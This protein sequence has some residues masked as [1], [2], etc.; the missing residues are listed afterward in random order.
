V[1]M[2][3][4]R[5]PSARWARYWPACPGLVSRLRQVTLP[6]RTPTNYWLQPEYR[7]NGSPNCERRE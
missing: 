7:P 5:P 6:G 3:V 2:T 1:A 4:R